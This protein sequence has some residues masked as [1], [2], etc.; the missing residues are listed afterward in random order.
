[1]T[2]M[3]EQFKTM[4]KTACFLSVKPTQPFH[5]A[6]S[7]SDGSVIDISS[8]S[9]SDLWMNGGFFL[10][11]NEIFKYLKDHEELVEEPFKRLISANQLATSRY[12]GFWMNMD[13]FKDKQKL[14]EMYAQG[15]TPWEVWKS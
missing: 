4:N 13:T 8:I 12:E 11:K 9:K 2:E 14:D 6:H 1:M 3:V 15:D 5:I 10:F 7:K